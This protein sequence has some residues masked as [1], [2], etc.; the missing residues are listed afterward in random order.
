MRN[1]TK[2]GNHPF[3]KYN[4][5]TKKSYS[6]ISLQLESYVYAMWCTMIEFF[7]YPSFLWGSEFFIPFSNFDVLWNRRFT[8][9]TSCK[10]EKLQYFI[11]YKSFEKVE[12]V[13]S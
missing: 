8:L 5:L 11:A 6:Y 10:N 3:N 9:S 12:D 7:T 2:R 1:M 13:I 4:C